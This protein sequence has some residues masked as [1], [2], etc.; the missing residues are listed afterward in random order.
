LRSPANRKAGKREDFFVLNPSLTPDAR[1]GDARLVWTYGTYLANAGIPNTMPAT[2]RRVS[3]AADLSERE[4]LTRLGNLFVEDSD[5][6][7][8]TVRP[9]LTATVERIDEFVAKPL[10]FACNELRSR[11]RCAT[12]IVVAS[13]SR[14]DERHHEHTYPRV[15]ARSLHASALRALEFSPSAPW[16]EGGKILS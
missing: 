5:T 13:A 6:R 15:F 16:R 4:I 11:W 7:A 8:R 3:I 14:R 1:V 9:F 10:A 12:A 2:R